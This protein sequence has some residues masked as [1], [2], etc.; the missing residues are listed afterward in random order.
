MSDRVCENA[1]PRTAR[2]TRKSDNWRWILVFLNYDHQSSCVVSRIRAKSSL[3]DVNQ[4]HY[5]KR[6]LFWPHV[7]E[8]RKGPNNA[9]S[10]VFLVPCS[11]TDAPSHVWSQ[12]CPF[13]H[14]PE[15]VCQRIGPV[16]LHTLWNHGENLSESFVMPLFVRCTVWSSVL[17]LNMRCPVS[18]DEHKSWSPWL[19]SRNPS[20][21]P[22]REATFRCWENQVMWDENLPGRW[23]PPWKN[24][25]FSRRVKA[26]EKDWLISPN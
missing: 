20:P 26:L 2:G 9:G 1:V 12:V 8:D 13:I 25:V 5:T 10:F 17:V 19:C 6:V 16:V 18:A 11:A 4:E 22:H 21:P 14:P 7:C 24:R 3:L 23:R 15:P